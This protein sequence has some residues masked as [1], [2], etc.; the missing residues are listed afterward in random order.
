MNEL[1]NLPS[2]L[3]YIFV[4]IY[5]KELLEKLPYGCKIISLQNYS[6]YTDY[7]FQYNPIFDELL[8]IKVPYC[9]E[10]ID[11]TFGY[12]RIKKMSNK[13]II[14]TS[15]L[16]ELQSRCDDFQRRCEDFQNQC[17]KLL[18]VNR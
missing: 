10:D 14:K 15:I 18:T 16:P 5:E 12:V 8:T 1:T 17:D 9:D 4:N 7:Q 11:D 6:N 2:T 3:K 13:I